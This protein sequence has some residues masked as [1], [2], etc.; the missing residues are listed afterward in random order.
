MCLAVPGELIRI[1]DR[2]PPG[3]ADPALPES[4]GD[5]RA[6]WRVGIVDFSGVQREVSLACLPEARVGDHLLVHVGFALS[7]V[8]P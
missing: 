3:L 5:D 1:E 6:L 8:E 7:V 2:L 4:S